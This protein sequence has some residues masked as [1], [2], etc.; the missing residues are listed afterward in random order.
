MDI[1]KVPNER[2]LELCRTYFRA[3]FAFLPFAWAINVVWFFNEAFNKPPY[4]EQK[5]IRRYVLFSA[6]GAA[7]WLVV[8]IAWI[9]IFQT[10]RAQWGEVADRMSFI[11]PLGKP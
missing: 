6:L 4:E 1:T 10:Y 5:Q 9:T 8:L 2:K 7:V 3:G 11:I